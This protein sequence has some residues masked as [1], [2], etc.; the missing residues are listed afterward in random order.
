MGLIRRLERITAG[1]LAA[2]LHAQE[3]PELALPGLLAE[4]DEALAQARRAQAKAHS[5]ERSAQRRLDELTGRVARLA[6]GA[7]LA[8]EAG[9]QATARQALTAQLQAERLLPAR[10]EALQAAQA[11][12]ADARRVCQQLQAVRAEVARRLQSLPTLDRAMTSAQAARDGAARG[13]RLLDEVARLVEPDPPSPLAPLE[14]PAERL[15]RDAE[16][17]RRLATLRNRLKD[18]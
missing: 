18:R 3:R 13:H 1:R 5:A 2:F 11:A 8:L 9:D 10:A 7:Q 14:A 15:T 17:Q 6:R 16:I 4:L 12:L